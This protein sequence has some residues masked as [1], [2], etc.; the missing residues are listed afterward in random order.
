MILIPNISLY[1]V[2]I[3]LVLFK[4]FIQWFSIFFFSMYNYVRSRILKFIIQN[5]IKRSVSEYSEMR[6]QKSHSAWWN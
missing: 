2:N 4:R 1:L 3:E 6:V 5:M